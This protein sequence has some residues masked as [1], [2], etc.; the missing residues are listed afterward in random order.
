[1]SYFVI[2]FFVISQNMMYFIRIKENIERGP[3]YIPSEENI[4]K[5]LLLTNQV[6]SL[7]SV[8]RM[9]TFVPKG[10]FL[11]QLYCWENGGYAKY[12][13]EKNS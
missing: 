12:R 11:F 13:G 4:T 8:G 9:T 6:V 1:M 5:V 10:F 3:K 2:D 7:F